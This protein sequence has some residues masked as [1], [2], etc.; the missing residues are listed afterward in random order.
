MCCGRLAPGTSTVLLKIF[1][2]F[3]TWLQS[4]STWN[5][6]NRWHNHSKRKSTTNILFPSI[7]RLNH[8]FGV[9]RRSRKRIVVV[10]VFVVC[11]L[12]Q[13]HF[14][15]SSSG[16][17]WEGRRK[18]RSGATKKLN[19]ADE[20]WRSHFYINTLRPWVLYMPTCIHSF[21]HS[22]THSLIYLIGVLQACFGPIVQSLCFQD[23]CVGLGL[24]FLF[25]A[26]NEVLHHGINRQHQPDRLHLNSSQQ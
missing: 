10:V 16:R 25:L 26:A 19:K 23:R 18:I 7:Q 14:L 2:C 22:T 1:R 11:R 8:S 5:Y 12:Q 15:C 17:L 4:P 9:W 24:V 6:N 13:T 21:N 3:K 20:I